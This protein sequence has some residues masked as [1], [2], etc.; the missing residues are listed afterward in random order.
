[1]KSASEVVENVFTGAMVV[2]GRVLDTIG[3][4]SFDMEAQVDKIRDTAN[5]PKSVFIL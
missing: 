2:L 1:M 5:A 4:I 3:V